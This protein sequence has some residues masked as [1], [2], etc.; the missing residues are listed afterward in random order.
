MEKVEIISPNHSE[1]AFR[2]SFIEFR[3]AEDAT[4]ALA[5]KTHYI[6]GRKYIISPANSWHQPKKDPSPEP[7]CD[8]EESYESDENLSILTLNDDC[9]LKVFSYLPMKEQLMLS[10]ISLRFQE[11]LELHF[12]T[13]HR[14]LKIH[15]FDKLTLMNWRELLQFCG[16]FIKS[17]V[18]CYDLSTEKVFDLIISFSPNIEALSLSCITKFLPGTFQKMNKK[19]P[20]LKKIELDD[21]KLNDKII[22]EMTRLNELS[23]LR[24]NESFQITGMYFKDF[25]HLKHLDINQCSN[26]QPKPFIE[27]LKVAGDLE[28]LNILRC[29]RFTNDVFNEIPISCK[30]L[31]KLVIGTT[32]SGWNLQ[33]VAEIESLESIHI[34][35]TDIYLKEEI[36]RD[37]SLKKADQ[38]KEFHLTLTKFQKAN[39]T[40]L[41]NVLKF[42]NL[43]K[44]TLQG[45][46]EMKN[47]YLVLVA[48]ELP[49]LKRASFAYN[50][51]MTQSG[52][53][54]F[55]ESCPFLMEIDLTHC[56]LGTDFSAELMKLLE[57]RR[58]KQNY[59][60]Q[61]KPFVLEL[62]MDQYRQVG[63]LVFF[64]HIC[65]HLLGV[66]GH[67]LCVI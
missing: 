22:K 12:K 57:N 4:K 48:K 5:K 59:E 58:S 13:H 27:F 8:V 26:I 42:K 6:S 40:D 19:T 28:S 34:Q 9:L 31:K 7:S 20:K 47:D 2:F 56:M 64:L 54:K 53:L 16:Q 14:C 1:S 45:F 18:Y 24:I 55:I 39:E 38:L 10:K 46:K 30:S 49:Q 15:E 41:Q 61:H 62:S 23:D 3:E 51:E 44:L 32:Y 66:V 65:S 33:K 63:S 67:V 60:E 25:R 17:V 37:L 29:N 52:I 36:I 50:E 11:V 21:C 43:D 35:H